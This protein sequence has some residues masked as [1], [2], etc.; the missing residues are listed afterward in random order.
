[1]AKYKKKKKYEIKPKNKTKKKKKRKKTQIISYVG[2]EFDGIL[3]RGMKKK[4]I[5]IEKWRIV[6]CIN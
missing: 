4:T 3:C 2:A 1:L 6:H 5:M